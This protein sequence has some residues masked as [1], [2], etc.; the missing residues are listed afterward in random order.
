MATNTEKVVVQVVVK[1]GKQLDNLTKK[2][3]TATK[4]A[5][6]LTKSMAKMTGGIL[7][8]STAFRAISQLVGSAIKTFKNYEFQM[9]KVK[10]I[11]G[12][13]EKDFKKLSIQPT[14]LNTVKTFG[15]VK[16]IIELEELYKDDYD[17]TTGTYKKMSTNMQLIYN[18][19]LNQFYKTFTGESTVPSHIKS[20][21]DI[22]LKQYDCSKQIN[23]YKGTNPL[24]KLGYS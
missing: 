1:G 9:A 21:K 16:G 3:G 24:L 23:A 20:F 15:D 2:T 13:S 11:T 6:S 19:D 4:S 17:L 18:D 14:C 12:A 5:G 8:A 22:P 10:A 7:A